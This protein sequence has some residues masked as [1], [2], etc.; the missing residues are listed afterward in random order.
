V[1]D[2][3]EYLPIGEMRQDIDLADA[4]DPIVDTLA[5]YQLPLYKRERAI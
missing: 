2:D 5:L 3:P 4:G 1:N